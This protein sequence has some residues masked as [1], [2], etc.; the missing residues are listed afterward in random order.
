MLKYNP[1]YTRSYKKGRPT[2]YYK[3]IENTYNEIRAGGVIFY[4]FQGG[5]LK[6][7]LIN[8]THDQ[9]Y[10]DFGG[11]T[12]MEDYT[13]LDTI[14]REIYEES[15]KIIKKKFIMRKLL[16][17]NSCELY[18]NKSKYLVFLI[19]LNFHVTGK[20]FGNKEIHDDIDR[21]VE[22]IDYEKYEKLKLKNKI[23]P[24]LNFKQ[25]EEEL[26]FIIY[27]NNYKS[28][29]DINNLKI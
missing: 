4:K 23:N 6:L 15:N 20:Q 7:L 22:W 8:K 26:N 27:N 3:G 5:K 19:K 2:F 18:N 9:L 29:Y 10:E 24:R 12:D 25:L 14:T 1:Y 28:I 16:N 11:K 21:T 17:K 13:I